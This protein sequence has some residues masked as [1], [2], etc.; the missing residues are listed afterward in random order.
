L[1]EYELI[2]S[3]KKGSEE[4]FQQ[5]VSLY[6]D[7]IYNTALGFVQNGED[8]EELAMD[9]FISVFEN[10]RSFRQEASLGT[11]IYRITVTRSLDFIRKKKRQKRRGIHIPFITSGEQAW[12]PPDFHHP[13]IQAEQKENAALLFKAIRQLPDQQQSAFLLQKMEGL[14]LQEIAAILKTSASAVESLLHRAKANLKKQLEAQFNQ[15][16]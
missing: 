12:E 2:E 7:R 9:V 16:K 8:A 1:H 14:S 6:K 3:L 5:L 10:I 15:N 11:W 4:A 13:G